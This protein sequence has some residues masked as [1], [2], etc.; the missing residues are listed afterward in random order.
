MVTYDSVRMVAGGSL[1]LVT[2]AEEGRRGEVTCSPSDF[3]WSTKFSASF[4]RPPSFS[5]LLGP[6][7]FLKSAKYSQSEKKKFPLLFNYNVVII[8]ETRIPVLR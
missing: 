4:D 5:A 7:A 6:F 8:A 2:G 3:N 1:L